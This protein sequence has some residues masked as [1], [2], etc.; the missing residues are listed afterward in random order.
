[1]CGS[2]GF[3]CGPYGYGPSGPCGPWCGPWCGPCALSLGPCSYLCCGGPKGCGPC[4][5]A[6]WPYG[7]YTC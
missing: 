3:G 2:F 7:L 1:M 5:P 6:C 4:G